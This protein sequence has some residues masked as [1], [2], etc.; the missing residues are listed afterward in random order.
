MF[1][2]DIL[3]P[4]YSTETFSYYLT[5]YFILDANYPIYSQFIPDQIG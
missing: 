5:I 2:N 3:K 1:P 4:C